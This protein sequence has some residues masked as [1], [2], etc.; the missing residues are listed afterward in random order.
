A[1]A[2]ECHLI[3]DILRSPRRAVR[4]A[5]TAGRSVGRRQEVDQGQA[6]R[7]SHVVIIFRYLA[8]LRVETP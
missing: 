8:R 7:H 6:A 5:R 2:L 4:A 1:G 3:R